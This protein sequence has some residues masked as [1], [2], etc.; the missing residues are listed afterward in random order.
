MSAAPA[1]SENIELTPPRKSLIS[2]V[3]RAWALVRSRER[4]RLQLVAGYGVLIAGLETVA[5]VL[6]F[7]VITLLDGQTVTGVTG[8]LIP[9]TRLSDHER[10][11]E[12]LVLLTITALLFVGRSMLSILGLWL[13]A[14]AA[15]AAEADLVSRLL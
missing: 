7:A 9:G 1:S 12:A 14:G 13:T 10:Y 6:L 8:S 4:R 3:R 2:E 15:N 11:H 5:L